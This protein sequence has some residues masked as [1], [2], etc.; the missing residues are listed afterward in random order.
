M[1]RC[2]YIQPTDHCVY[3]CY[4]FGQIGL[5]TAEDAH[6]PSQRIATV[7]G[8]WQR[9]CVRSVMETTFGIVVQIFRISF[10]QNLC[11]DVNDRVFPDSCS[12]NSF[13]MLFNLYLYY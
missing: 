5:G 9:M 12:I 7:S 1:L 11:F 13:E 2:S 6:N 3:A 8:F 10:G 4:T